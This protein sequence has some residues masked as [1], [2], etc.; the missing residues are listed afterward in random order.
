[1]VSRRTPTAFARSSWV[2]FC[3]TRCSRMVVLSANACSPLFGDLL[4][5]QY[6]NKYEHAYGKGQWKCGGEECCI[7]EEYHCG[8]CDAEQCCLE[9]KC[10]CCGFFHVGDEEFVGN[11]AEVSEKDEECEERDIADLTGRQDKESEEADESQKAEFVSHDVCYLF[12]T[13]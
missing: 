7:A 3:R 8:I 13:L 11:D 9:E 1:M 4:R 6:G 2:I 5:D 12:L 10:S